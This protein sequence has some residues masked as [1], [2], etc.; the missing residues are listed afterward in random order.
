MH[1]PDAD[2]WVCAKLDLI[3]VL[4]GVF[5]T[6]EIR[7]TTLSALVVEF[8]AVRISF[9]IFLMSFASSSSSTPPP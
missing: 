6:T 5:A 3:A 2:S 1:A 9:L 8:R 4:V 7:L